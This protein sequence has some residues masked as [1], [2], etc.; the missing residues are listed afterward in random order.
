VIRTL[1]VL[2]QINIST[3]SLFLG[4]ILFYSIIASQTK[5]SN[6]F[7]DSFPISLIH[8]EFKLIGNDEFHSVSIIRPFLLPET[9]DIPE[10]SYINQIAYNSNHP[11]IDNYGEFFALKG[12]NNLSN[13]RIS[14]SNKWLFLNLEPYISRK[15]NLSSIEHDQFGVFSSV[16]NSL[17]NHGYYYR[18]RDV[19][20]SGFKQSALILHYN[21]I[22]LGYGNMSNWW[23]PGFHSSIT[24]S[25][26]S[27]G[28]NSIFFGSFKTINLK[29]L[30][31]GFRIIISELENHEQMP[32]YFSGLAA[33]ATYKSEPRLTFG[34]F[35]Y[36]LSGGEDI[37]A[38]TNFE[39][40]WSIKDAAKLI[41]EPLFGQRKAVMSY[42]NINTPGYDRWDQVLTGFIDLTFNRSLLKLY[43][44]VSSDDNR[45]NFTDLKAHWDHTL[46]YMLGFRKYFLFGN[47]KI[48]I[49]SEYLS[50]KISN[51][52]KFWRGDLNQPN[53]Y[54]R[55][56]FDYSTYRGRKYGAHSGP[57]S[58]D[59][60]I[61]LGF[62]SQ[63]KSIFFYYNK[64]RHGIKGLKFPE[65]KQELNFLYNYDINDHHSIF[66]N[67]EYEKVY[68]WLNN[69]GQVSNSNVLWLGYSISL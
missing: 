3:R 56:Q 38:I 46:G 28:F 50:T 29:K 14:Y 7:L 48:I 30:G 66:I 24:L 64:E 33:Y 11:N 45:A 37:S 19:I 42:T 61:L 43:I 16:N 36:H 35:R 9:E 40:E 15:Q 34:F 58:D 54:T 47:N 57:S 21:G 27:P 62:Y 49:A 10:M 8:H 4:S 25:S 20:R 65:K 53:Y 51:T 31:F 60:I 6:I 2:N 63:N 52:I 26:N 67:I 68:N 22:G 1:N 5:S 32:Y 17:Y 69:Q 41:F 59:L 44:E 12:I 13:Y 39:G 18:G 55:K 23:G